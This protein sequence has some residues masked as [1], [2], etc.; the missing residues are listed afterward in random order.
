[1]SL[2][3]SP[4]FTDSDPM[5]TNLG[6][7]NLDSCKLVLGPEDA[8]CGVQH[9]YA[10]WSSP[11]GFVQLREFA[12]VSIRGAVSGQSTRSERGSFSFV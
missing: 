1:M 10:I 9:V 8:E 3:I 12:L 4:E 6:H 5:G 7:Q 11:S 2:P